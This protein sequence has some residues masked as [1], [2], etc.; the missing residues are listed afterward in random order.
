MLL[1]YVQPMVK[2]ADTILRRLKMVFGRRLVNA[3]IKR[4]FFLHFCAGEWFAR[5]AVR[6]G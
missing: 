1:Y 3:V 2:Y 6:T 5:S 4:T